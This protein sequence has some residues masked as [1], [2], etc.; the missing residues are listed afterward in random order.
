MTMTIT[1]RQ[2]WVTL[3]C[4][5]LNWTHSILHYCKTFTFKQRDKTFTF[6]Q[7]YEKQRIEIWKDKNRKKKKAKAVARRRLRERI[8]SLK[9]EKEECKGQV[10]N[11]HTHTHRQ[12]E[13]ERDCFCKTTIVWPCGRLGGAA[14]QQSFRLFNF[15]TM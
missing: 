1:K 9:E 5:T 7:R 15:S 13:R 3:S 2:N 6:K 12:R 11:T 8:V 10:L 14:Y 4:L